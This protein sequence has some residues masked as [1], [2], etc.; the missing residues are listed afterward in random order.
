MLLLLI[1]KPNKHKE[2]I[3]RSYWTPSQ[4]LSEETFISFWFFHLLWWQFSQVKNPFRIQ[5]KE[6]QREYSEIRKIYWLVL[7]FCRKN[8]FECSHVIEWIFLC[9]SLVFVSIIINIKVIKT[10]RYSFTN[11]WNT[12]GCWDSSASLR[13]GRWHQCQMS[14]IKSLRYF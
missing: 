14:S 10:S 5:Y 6:L 11:K 8:W 2:K 4:R 9:L 3:L 1:Q 12:I 13:S 7:W